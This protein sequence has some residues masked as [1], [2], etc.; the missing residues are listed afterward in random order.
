M[1]PKN[2]TNTLKLVNNSRSSS[3]GQKMNHFYR[4]LVEDG[5]RREN[6]YHSL[7]TREAKEVE[8]VYNKSK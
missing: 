1:F 3:I 2:R 4:I 8:N 6:L 5:K 7:D